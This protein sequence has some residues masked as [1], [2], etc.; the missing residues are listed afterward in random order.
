M[1]RYLWVCGTVA[2]LAAGAG[3][4]DSTGPASITGTY[5][6]RTI[7]GVDLPYALPIEP[8]CEV[9]LSPAVC[10]ESVR[11]EARSG[12]VLLSA[13][14]T[15]HIQ[16]LIRRHLA[17]GANT[18]VTSNLRGDWSLQGDLIALVDSAGAQRSGSLDGGVLTIDVVPNMDWAYRK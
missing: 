4:G 13:D 11:I 15:Y 8:A 10:N 18:D 3:C 16:T 2:I 9:L 1:R 14:S 12:T 6:L 17:S 7:D 5:A